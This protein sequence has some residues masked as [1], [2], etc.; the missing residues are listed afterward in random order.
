MLVPGDLRGVPVS[1]GDHLEFEGTVK[2]ASKGV[3]TVEVP[4]LEKIITCK[5]AGQLRLH[6][7]T[8]LIGDKVLLKVSPYD[9]DT[10]V[11]HRRL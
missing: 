6:R 7:I 3:F 11:I 1:E 2:T 9:T 5:P 4:L 10:G 8:L